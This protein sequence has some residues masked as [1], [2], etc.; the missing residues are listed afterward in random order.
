VTSVDP[1][2]IS[3]LTGFTS[4][5]PSRLKVWDWVRRYYARNFP[6]AEHVTGTSDARPFNKAAA[7]NRAASQAS[8]DVFLLA[9]A[10]TCLDR[11][12][13][14]RAGDRLRAGETAW[15]F[16]A[17]E[18]YRL[19]ERQTAACLRKPP[20]P[21]GAIAKG[22]CRWHSN[23]LRKLAG[24]V[25]VTREAWESAGGMDERFAEGWGC[26]DACFTLVLATLLGEPAVMNGYKAVHLEH[27]AAPGPEGTCRWDGQARDYAN[28]ELTNRYA[29]AN[30]RPG[31]MRELV[32][33]ARVIAWPQSGPV[34]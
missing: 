13:V 32:N 31:A 1:G 27:A 9:D 34:S 33:E 17:S 28:L 11:G 10:D 2:R 19:S 18:V 6:G 7:I 5:D 20:V 8:G 15:A 22:A 24:W 3:I 16:P 26:E 25:I 21:F 12:G 30:G 23:D 4:D 14:V 29:A